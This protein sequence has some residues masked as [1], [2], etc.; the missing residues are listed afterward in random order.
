MD[1][2]AEQ[3]IAYV[4]HF[5][6]GGFTPLQSDTLRDVGARLKATPTGVALAESRP[7]DR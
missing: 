2:L 5:P 6:L 4:P 1:S 7:L 3:G